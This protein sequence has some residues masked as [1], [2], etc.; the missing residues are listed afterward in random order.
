MT[1]QNAELHGITYQDITGND[2]SGRFQQF[3]APDD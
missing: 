1:N 3:R 2:I